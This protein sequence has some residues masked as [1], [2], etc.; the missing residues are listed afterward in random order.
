MRRH[1]SRIAGLVLAI[2]IC[3]AALPFAYA[4]TETLQDCH[5]VTNTYTETKAKN[6]SI[7]KLWHVETAQPS[8]TEEINRIA[9]RWAEE[10]GSNLPDG[11]NTGDQNSRLDVE[12][13]YS[14]T[15]LSWMS[16]MVQARTIYH[17]ELKDQRF[18]TRTYDMKTGIRITLEMIFD[19]ESEAWDLLA[20][21]VRET[22]TGYW[23]DVEPN[24]EALD[25]LC[26]REALKDADFTLHG[27]SLVLHY[28][29][30]LLYEGKQTLMEVPF[31]YP[32]IRDMMDEKAYEETDNLAYYK[33]AA[34]TF[35][36]GP[37]AKNSPK[38]LDTL[39][40]KGA[41]GTFFVIGN[42]IDENPWV[43]QREHDDGHAVG[44]HNW[45]H[46]SPTK[47][48]AKGLRAMPAQ[49]N[50]VMIK[51]IGIPVRYDRVPG[52]AYP[53]MRKAKVEWAYIQ[54]SLD[55]YDWRAERTVKQ[56]VSKV[57]KKIAD[58]DIILCHDI[59]DHTPEAAKQIIEYLEEQGYM[60]LTIDE[61]F[62]KDGVTLEAGQV[63]YRCV[64]GDTSK[65]PGGT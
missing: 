31:F 3:V 27:M 51:T 48:S 55:T 57:K 11:Q 36:D 38:V 37:K 43:V 54:W 28:P 65:K 47:V 49:V 9:G 56:I 44:S 5:K 59:K 6:Q 35:D 1:Y 58:G 29:A 13:R 32:E 42:I 15:G 19:E 61:L 26:S 50:K 30:S 18:T 12:I 63:Y 23:P 24:A 60:L 10:L 46:G 45:H 33:T 20:D 2:A 8:V 7:V 39:M 64:N 4:K 25:R 14:R 40:Q 53:A 16:F 34:L 22:L 41:R 52:G 62:A 21:R 17:R